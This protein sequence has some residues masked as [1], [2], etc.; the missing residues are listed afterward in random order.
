MPLLPV[1]GLM[2]VCARAFDEKITFS[3]QYF[4]FFLIEDVFKKTTILIS[5]LR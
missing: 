3:R 4:N 2:S 1:V 5:V